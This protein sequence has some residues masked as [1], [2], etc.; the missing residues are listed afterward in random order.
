MMNRTTLYFTAPYQVE[1]RSEPLPAGKPGQVL[2]RTLYSAISTGTELLIFRGQAPAN[3][4]ADATIKDLAGSLAFPLKYGYS[5]V[6]E[7][8][9][10]V[11]KKHRG[12]LGKRVFAF[13]PH[14]TLFWAD[15]TTLHPLNG[16]VKPEDAL[17]LP[18][19][20]T[21][22]NFL[23]DAVPILGEQAVVFGQGVVGLLTTAL[24]ARTPLS[25]LITL[26][27]HPLRREMSLA[28]GATASL[29]PTMPDTLEQISALLQANDASGRADL[30]F[31]LSGAPQA[32]QQA[33]DI[34]GFSGRI[35]IGSWYGRK[36][37]TL[38]LGGDFHRS[39]IRLISSQV[40]TLAPALQGRWTKARR[41]QVAWSWLSI[42]HPSDLI[43]RKLP[44][45][46]APQAYSLLDKRPE[47]HLQII[48]TYT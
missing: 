46:Q 38:N 34:T 23:Q 48:F 44:F 26:D 18:N 28:M 8:V 21:A 42:V 25:Q 36:P 45:D 20:E 33:I 6:G 27:R 3:M 1:L 37:V 31:E 24:L 41:L 16:D 10:V 40:S 30:A 11:D 35:L 14:E 7:V 39:R 29:D 9:D 32:L 17:F 13:H 4:A 47:K 43:T 19:M 2:V 15:P 22:V 12:W 5:L